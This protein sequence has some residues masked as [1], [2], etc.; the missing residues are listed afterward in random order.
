MNEFK[1]SENQPTRRLHRSATDRVI[2]GV[3][4]G[5]AEY[6][7]IDPSLVRIAFVVGTL[8]G[9]VGLLI[10]IVLAVILPVDAST[11][12]YT[13]YSPERSHALAGTVL[14]VLGA[15]LLLGNMGWAPWLSGN[16]FWPAVLVL[17]GVGL[18]LRTPRTRTFE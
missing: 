12:A 4:G 15:L 10:Y 5:I 11:P 13:A 3:C 9:G 18:L 2:A 8:W 1:A 16:L 14:V 17:V 7:S 6:L